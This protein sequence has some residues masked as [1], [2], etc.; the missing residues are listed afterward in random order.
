MV[1]ADSRRV[2]PAP[3]Y[4][5]TGPPSATFP[6]GTVTLSGGAFQLASGRSLGGLCPSYNPGTAVTA[7]VWAHP[8]SLATTWGIPIGLFS[9][10][11]LDVSVPPV[12]PP[13]GVT[14]H[15]PAGLPHSD[16]RG[17]QAVCAYPRIF[18]ACHVLHRLW[19]PR[20]PR[21]RPYLLSLP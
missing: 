14:G 15:K 1:L 20:H 8:R 17:S 10:G 19:M 18:A 3:R 21:T 12:R 7:P 16:T 13:C 9:S 11:Y 4:S 5:G 2:S 6:Y